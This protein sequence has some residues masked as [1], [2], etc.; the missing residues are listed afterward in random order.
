M[1]AAVLSGIDRYPRKCTCEFGI[2][3]GIEMTSNK[4]LRSMIQCI[5]SL[6][7]IVQYSGDVHAAWIDTPGDFN[8]FLSSCSNADKKLMLESLGEKIPA[9]QSNYDSAIRNGLVYRSYNKATYFFRSSDYVDYHEIV[10]WAAS[11]VGVSN[12]SGKSTFEIEGKIERM[13]FE[14]GNDG[15]SSKSRTDLQTH[16]GY[17]TAYNMSQS[18]SL[19]GAALAAA[20]GTAFVGIDQFF[21]PNIKEVVAF[22][23]TVHRIKIKRPGYH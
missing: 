18:G 7:I 4:M 8:A 23:I 14:K 22:I 5:L 13:V 12:Y 3:G 9:S 16:A 11:E 21:S 6:L 10:A 15:I 17:A 20:V 1:V 2:N 19:T